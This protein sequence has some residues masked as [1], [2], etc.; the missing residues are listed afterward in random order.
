MRQLP[1]VHYA[2]CAWDVSNIHHKWAATVVV[3]WKDA[4]GVEIVDL[5][6]REIDIA[7][8]PVRLARVNAPPDRDALAEQSINE[9]KRGQHPRVLVVDVHRDDVRARCEG[10]GPVSSRRWRNERQEEQEEKE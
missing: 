6:R 3:R 7:R 2:V 9:A 4:I 5:V 1:V 8:R 10:A